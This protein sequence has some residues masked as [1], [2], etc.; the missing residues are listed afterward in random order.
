MF[1]ITIELKYIIIIKL[2]CINYQIWLALLWNR[3][4]TKF[5]LQILICDMWIRFH[6]CHF[7]W[8]YWPLSLP[9]TLQSSAF[10]PSE[11]TKHPLELSILIK[12]WIPFV[13]GYSNMKNKCCLE[14]HCF[15]KMVKLF[16][17]KLENELDGQ[18]WASSVQISDSHLHNIVTLFET[19]QWTSIGL[20]IVY[21]P[22]MSD[23]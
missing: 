21:V 18:I 17:S 11:L 9:D 13:V 10:N 3:C 1:Q 5:W 19:W 16:F 22:Y 6:R 4:H 7:F 23:G 14:K 2:K 8:K 20:Y 15:N 12:C